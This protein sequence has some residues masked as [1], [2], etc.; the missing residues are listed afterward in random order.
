[1]LLE[2]G[3]NKTKNILIV[4]LIIDDTIIIDVCFNNTFWNFLQAWTGNV[5]HLS[6]EFFNIPLV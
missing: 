3:E 1:M 2:S 6:V 4:K 5:L